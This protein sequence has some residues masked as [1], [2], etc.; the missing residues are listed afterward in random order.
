MHHYSQKELP[1][2]PSC[3][4]HLNVIPTRDHRNHVWSEADMRTGLRHAWNTMFSTAGRPNA[5]PAC[6][7]GGREGCGGEERGAGGTGKGRGR[8]KVPQHKSRRPSSWRSPMPISSWC[9]RQSLIIACRRASSTLVSQSTLLKGS[10]V[11]ARLFLFPWWSK[12]ATLMDIILPLSP[13]LFPLSLLS[14]H[15]R[16]ALA[17]LSFLSVACFSPPALK[18]ILINICLSA[19]SIFFPY[20]ISELRRTWQ[21]DWPATY[22]MSSLLSTSVQ[23]PRLSCNTLRSLSFVWHKPFVMMSVFSK[24]A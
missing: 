7:E 16:W 10:P 19:S 22:K 15:F 9:S 17:T 4:H 20:L 18:L 8:W 3:V 11:Q 6:R 13:W 21:P 23:A 5:A 24:Q 2:V 1:K 14:Y 12:R